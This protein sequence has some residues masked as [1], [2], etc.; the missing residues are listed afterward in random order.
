MHEPKFVNEILT[1]LKNNLDKSVPLRNAV[2]N[3]RL[4]PFSHV[5]S[6]A[7]QETFREFLKETDFKEVRLN[8]IVTGEKLF[9]PTKNSD[10]Q[11]D[12]FLSILGNYDII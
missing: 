2:V 5:T 6:G 7:L 1:I 9:I 12:Y 10:F 3:I 11:S 4:S 8:I